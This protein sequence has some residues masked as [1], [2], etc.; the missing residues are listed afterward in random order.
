MPHAKIWIVDDQA[1]FDGAVEGGLQPERW[2]SREG[3][4][5]GCRAPL[6]AHLMIDL[7]GAF[8]DPKTGAFWVDT[9]KE[10]RACDLYGKGFS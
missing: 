7:K 4:K 8:I 5:R 2:W 9:C 6:P 1:A 10:D 3:K